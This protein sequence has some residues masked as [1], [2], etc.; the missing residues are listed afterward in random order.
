MS[1]PDGIDWALTIQLGLNDDLT[2]EQE[3]YVKDNMELLVKFHDQIHAHFKDNLPWLGCPEG[4]DEDEF[5]EQ[6]PSVL[7]D[8]SDF[9]S[10]TA[11]WAMAQTLTPSAAFEF[12]TF[13]RYNTNM[14]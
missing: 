1:L 7:Y 12:A 4:A 2:E 5:V 9:H 3:Q 6:N 14:A 13:V 8:E 10:L 11:G